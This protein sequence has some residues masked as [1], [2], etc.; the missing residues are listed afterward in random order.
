LSEREFS[1]LPEEEDEIS[2]IVVE[3]VESDVGIVDL[4]EGQLMIAVV[5]VVVAVDSSVAE[6][7]C[8][9]KRL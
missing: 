8:S 6:E 3:I 5:L 7:V 1:E 2:L 4:E 9:F